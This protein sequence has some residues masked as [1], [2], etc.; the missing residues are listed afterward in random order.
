VTD[1][2]VNRMS[3]PDRVAVDV[4]FAGVPVA[5]FAAAVAWYG[6]L[7]GR[8]PDVLVHDT[9]VM[10]CLADAAWLYVVEDAHRAGHALVTV[11]VPDLDRTMVQIGDRGVTGP[12]VE[13]VGDAG[14]K[15][16][17]TDPE[18]NVIAFI[19]VD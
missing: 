11:A 19:D 18:G 9:E 3:V 5:D 10:W 6:R 8:P 12:P 13:A 17:I 1:L 2:G 15:A 16:S 14:R 4:L 7:W